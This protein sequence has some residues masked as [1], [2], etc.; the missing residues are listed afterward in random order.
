M[1]GAGDECY[2]WLETKALSAED[3]VKRSGLERSYEGH[4]SFMSTIECGIQL[5]LSDTVQCSVV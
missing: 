1:F 2:S 3:E 4:R 5:F